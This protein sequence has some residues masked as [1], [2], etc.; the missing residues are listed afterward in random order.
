MENAFF[1]ALNQQY[2]NSNIESYQITVK[3]KEGSNTQAFLA[4][5]S[6]RKLTQNLEKAKTAYLNGVDTLEEYKTTKIEFL[7]RIKELEEVIPFSSSCT[8]KFQI[9]P[10]FNQLAKNNPILLQLVIKKIIY[11]SKENCFKIYFI[12]N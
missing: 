1:T 7:K 12:T 11:C 8:E 6:I 3:Q 10:T 2:N 9:L 5:N 4:K